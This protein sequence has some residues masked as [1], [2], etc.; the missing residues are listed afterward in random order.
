MTMANISLRMVVMQQS[1]GD[2][3]QTVQIQQMK[4]QHQQQAIIQQ[5]RN[6]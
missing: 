4:Q 1:Q 2:K 6:T 3:Q 5:V